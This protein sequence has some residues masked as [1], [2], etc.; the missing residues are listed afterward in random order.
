M[1]TKQVIITFS[2][3]N[4]NWIKPICIPLLF[5]FNWSNSF[6][7]FSSFCFFCFLSFGL[8]VLF[9]FICCDLIP[10]K[11]TIG[12]CFYQCF[13]KVCTH[14]SD[15]MTH[16]WKKIRTSIQRRL[17]NWKLWTNSIFETNS[18]FFFSVLFVCNMYLRVP[19]VYVPMQVCDMRYNKQKLRKLFNFVA[20]IV[21]FDTNWKMDFHYNAAR[22]TLKQ[23]FRMKKNAKVEKKK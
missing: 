12:F 8:F 2:I 20:N 3:S 21:M 17:S 5:Y 15:D 7:C 4:F 11:H 19:D 22:K 14:D 23:I 10:I 16:R 1:N 9:P 13:S 18:L 6:A